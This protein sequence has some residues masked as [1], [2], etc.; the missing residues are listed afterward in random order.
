MNDLAAKLNLW[1][2]RLAAIARTGL[3]FEP[4]IYDRERYEELLKL[5]AEMAAADSSLQTDTQLS[6]ALYDKWRASVQLG[7]KGYVTPQVGIG[8]IVFNESN[9][10][11]LIKRPGGQ[12]LYPTGWADV[13]YSP[14]QVAV[15]EVFEETGIHVTP[16]RLVAVY[17]VRSLADSPDLSIHFYSLVFYCRYDG[18]KLERHP[19]ETLDAGFF[20]RENLPRPLAREDL[21]WVEHAWAAHRGDLAQAYFDR[22]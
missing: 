19:T 17:D 1:T 4:G 8:A 13:G 10:I 20:S 14:G 12:W 18:G 5:G 15:K 16:L 6:Q 3:A 21:N 2:Q 22:P 7:V 11:L 9:E